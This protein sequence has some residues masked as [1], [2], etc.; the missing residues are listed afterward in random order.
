MS[1]IRSTV[2]YVVHS[3]DYFCLDLSVKTMS[4]YDWVTDIFIV[5]TDDEQPAEFGKLKEKYFP[6][7][8][9][10][11]QSYGHGFDKSVADGGFDEVRCRNEVIAWARE[12]DNEF[13]IQCDADEFYTP[14][15]GEILDYMIR[16]NIE[17][18]VSFSHY[19]FISP[20][21]Y[22]WDTSCIRG[23]MHDPHIRV[24]RKTD[25]VWYH[26]HNRGRKNHTQDC[27]INHDKDEMIFYEPQ[28][29]HMHLHDM[30]GP[31]VNPS[32]N[33][34]DK[35][36]VDYKIIDPSIMPQHYIEA[37]VERLKNEN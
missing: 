30:I 35:F 9:E 4:A 22:V 10:K 24:W 26:G 18:V 1:R 32:R 25:E 27:S 15:L 2:W 3:S 6:K 12:F 13:L 11:W 29:C 33:N 34:L 20:C 23:I 5:Y 31:K 7:V 28:P 19:P 21:I 16:D 37:F 17:K 36:G 14:L 8:T